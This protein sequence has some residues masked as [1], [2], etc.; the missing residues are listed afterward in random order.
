MNNNWKNARREELEDEL[1]RQERRGKN[2]KSRH[3]ITTTGLAQIAILICLAGYAL[4]AYLV[5]NGFWNVQ[6]WK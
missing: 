6:G 5:A 3:P 1:G 2:S 4:Y